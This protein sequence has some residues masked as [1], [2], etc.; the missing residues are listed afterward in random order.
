VYPSFVIAQMGKG[1]GWPQYR[2][3]RKNLSIW[4]GLYPVGKKLWTY[5]GLFVFIFS[6][7]RCVHLTFTGHENPPV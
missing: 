5:P 1:H 3:L 4:T 2:N 7:L 6:D